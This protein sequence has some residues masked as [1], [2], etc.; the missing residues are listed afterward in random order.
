MIPIIVKHFMCLGLGGALV[1]TL[2]TM[3]FCRTIYNH[4]ISM[5]YFPRKIMMFYVH[6]FRSIVMTRIFSQSYALL[7]IIMQKE[8]S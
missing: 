5:F 8:W 3:F 1:S 7:I 2:A 4:N 6:M